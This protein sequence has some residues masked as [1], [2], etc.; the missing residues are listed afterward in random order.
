[1]I[2]FTDCRK[3][4]FKIVFKNCE[5]EIKTSSIIRPQTLI[6]T[7]IDYYTYVL[8]ILFVNQKPIFWILK[9]WTQNVKTRMQKD[10]L[11]GPMTMLLVY[12]KNNVIHSGSNS[13]HG[14]PW[15]S[16]W[17]TSPLMVIFMESHKWACEKILLFT[18][19]QRTDMS[20]APIF[21]RWRFTTSVSWTCMEKIIYYE[22]F[23]HH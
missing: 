11:I 17:S 23:F 12:N 2:L 7:S 5:N 3:R 8:S 1:M 13:H 15:T 18:C 6:E 10:R 14:R 16:C 20:K 21:C 9:I 19:V 22:F 4:I